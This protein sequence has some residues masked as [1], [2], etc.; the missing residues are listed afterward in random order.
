MAGKKWEFK[1]VDKH[2]AN[3]LANEC[4]VDPMIALLLSGR[5]LVDPM[6]I[7]TFVYGDDTLS[8][9]FDLPDMDKAVS[10]VQEAI[11]KNQAIAVC[12]D[13]D[14]DGVTASALL[15]TYL[16]RKGCRVICNIPERLEKGYGLHNSTI[17]E[18]NQ[19]N[20]DLIIT[21]D[22]GIGCV[23]EIAHA[24]AL[25]IDVVVTDHHRPGIQLPPAVA[26]VDPYIRTSDGT[27]R[28][29]SGVGVAFK[30]ICALD[31]GDCE[32]LLEE[33]GDLVAIGTVADVVPLIDENRYL[34]Q[35]GLSVLNRQERIGLRELIDAADIVSETLGADQ[36]AYGIA[37][38]I[39]AAGRMGRSFRA[40]ELLTTDDVNEARLLSSEIC[41]ENMKR[42]E[43]EGI[44]SDTC[45]IQHLHSGIHFYDR[46]IVIA[47]YAWHH[48]VL[49]IVAARLCSQFGKPA[50]VL[51][52][53]G[54]IAKGSARSLDGF[55]LFTA[56]RNCSDTLIQFGGHTLAAGLTLDAANIDEFRERINRYAR[57][58]GDRPLPTLHIDCKLSPAGAGEPTANA[59]RCLA[60]HGCQNPVPV[61]GLMNMEIFGI[62][63]VGGG[64]SIRLTL[65]RDG[66]SIVC[67]KFGTG[68]SDFP[69][70]IGDKVDLA[71]VFRYSTYKGRPAYSLVIQDV[72]PAGFNDIE[73]F[74]DLLL[75]E[76]MMADGAL[77]KTQQ[78]RL[79]PTR[80][81][82]SIVYR[83]IRG[84][85]N[86]KIPPSVLMMH[87]GYAVSPGKVFVT[88]QIFE[89]FGFIEY[90]FDGDNIYVKFL[91]P[92]GKF[93]L[94]NSQ[95]LLKLKT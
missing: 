90:Y 83:Y 39:N 45:R 61:F 56:L 78:E 92:D 36:I 81:E 1:K 64:R 66:T 29:Y 72:R 91:N 7:E 19:Y 3:E 70:Q 27:F 82:M 77:D 25:G 17:D 10:R 34:V 87:L 95:I 46:V 68:R 21:V 20:I 49:G 55:D 69:F 50:I 37:P 76:E 22:N 79:T 31:G 4:D 60:P 2:L 67:M 73:L 53:D 44:V 43:V 62:Q 59:I 11:D 18:L 42:Q 88:L 40:F 58:L 85:D 63:P 28:D 80:E 57:Q 54:D 71:V 48:G 47:G 12:G 8:D 9:P 86:L 94:S 5:G 65:T 24:N 84:K 52:I 32:A 16:H 26:V 13:Y 33:Y 51:S 6:D 74:S 15:Y 30:L 14:A 23:D 75:F 41:F 89:E 93:D 35:R 38:R